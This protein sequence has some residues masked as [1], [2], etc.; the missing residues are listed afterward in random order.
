[1]I[2]FSPN[3]VAIVTGAFGLLGRQHTMAL[4]EIDYKVYALDNSQDKLSGFNDF[5]ALEDSKKDMIVPLIVDLRSE[6]EIRTAINTIYEAEGRIDSIVNN[7]AKNPVPSILKLAERVE[8]FNV[9]A[10]N[11]EVQVGLTSAILLAKYA[12]PYMKTGGCIVNI[13]SDLA[14]IA[15]DQRIYKSLGRDSEGNYFVKPLS[16]SVIK[17][18]ILGFT[19]YLST[20]LAPRAIRV[21]ALS[22]GGVYAGQEDALV[23]SLESLIPLGRMANVAEY[24]GALQFLC[25]D[26][27]SY[28]TGQNLVVDGGR[29]VW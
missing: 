12:I 13:A 1:M 19:R 4:R 23:C 29:S 3:K 2:P 11:E 15:P 6:N 9:D 10:W 5:V 24:R 27:S 16:Y 28:M 22:P 26:A 7:A 14:V 25:S 18:G 21:N 17:T 8:N 20:Y